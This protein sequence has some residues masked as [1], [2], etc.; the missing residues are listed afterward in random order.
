MFVFNIAFEH[1][2]SYRAMSVCS[3]TFPNALPLSCRNAMLQTQDMT[4]YPVTVFR[5]RAD[6]SQCYP[7]MW[8]VTLEYTTTYFNVLGQTRSGNASTTFHTHQRTLNFMMLIWWL[9]VRS[10]VDSVPYP[11]GLEPGTCG[12]RIH[13]GIRWPTAAS[14]VRIVKNRCTLY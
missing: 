5:H 14:S 13:Y 7:L 3:S 6:L 1:L 9:S 12:L 4:P 8:N 11:L 10:S 2:W